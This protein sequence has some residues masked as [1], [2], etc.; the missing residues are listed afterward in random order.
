MKDVLLETNIQD[1]DDETRLRNRTFQQRIDDIWSTTTRWNTELLNESKDSAE[2]IMDMRDNYLHYIRNLNSSFLIEINKCFDHVNNVVLPEQDDQLL[3]TQNNLSL[4]LKE[5]VPSAIEKQSGE[6]SRQLKRAY[7]NFD[8]E[9]KK[10]E[11]RYSYVHK[12]EAPLIFVS[13]L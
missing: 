4:F 9:K 1:L 11:K 7:E 12:Y 2:S 8:I 3:T 13:F 10:E 6:V 5:I